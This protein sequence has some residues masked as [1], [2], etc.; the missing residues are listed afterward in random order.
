MIFT[1]FCKLYKMTVVCSSRRVLN[2]LPKST[3]ANEVTEAQRT[4]I[5]QSKLVLE[6]KLLEPQLEENKE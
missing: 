3:Q 6:M 4:K 2:R 5:K 1:F